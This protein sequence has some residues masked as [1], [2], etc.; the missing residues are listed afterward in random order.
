MAKEEINLLMYV[1]D[2]YSLAL[3]NQFLIAYL[4]TPEYKNVE[5]SRNLQGQ[6]A[7]PCQQQ[8]RPSEGPGIKTTLH[9]NFNDISKITKLMRKFEK[10]PS[11][12]SL[13]DLLL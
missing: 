9:C 7:E 6:P 1:I 13:G 3:V 4:P 5:T 10:G 8:Q 2:C 12:Y 11:R